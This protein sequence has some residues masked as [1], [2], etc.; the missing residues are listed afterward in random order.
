V[1]GKEYSCQ[2]GKLEPGRIADPDLVSWKVEMSETIAG[3]SVAVLR[4]E[5]LP[6]LN[7]GAAIPEP[8]VFD[9]GKGKI[10]LG[11]LGENKSLQTYSGGMA[12][13]KVIILNAEKAN[14]S[15]IVLNLG[16]LVAS[17]EV[18]VNGKLAGSKAVSPWTFDLTGKLK[19]GENLIEVM[20]YNTLGNHYLTT[21]S[22]YIGRTDSG[23][24][25]PVKLIF[26]IN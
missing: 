14:S 19:P 13:R 26:G 22:Q 24:I 18:L 15:Q 8:I 9:C 23:L 11:D 4:M 1:A 10:S 3:S 20:V 5:Q 16:K 7:G 21:P 17:A 12:Y 25:G 2:K 6:G